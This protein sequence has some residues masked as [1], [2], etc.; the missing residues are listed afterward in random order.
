L[1]GR[2]T[3]LAAVFVDALLSPAS[4]ASQE[5]QINPQ[6]PAKKEATNKPF[7]N[8]DAG[9]EGPLQLLPPLELTAVDPPTEAPDPG[10]R[11]R[12]STPKHRQNA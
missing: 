10:Q 2:G 11:S 5:E 1:A 9:E 3:N 6:T 8:G 4:T 7:I 12:G